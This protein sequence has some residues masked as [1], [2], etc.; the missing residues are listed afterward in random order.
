MGSFNDHRKSLSVIAFI[1][2]TRM[3]LMSYSYRKKLLVESVCHNLKPDYD[4]CSD[5]MLMT[6]TL[7]KH[8]IIELFHVLN[9]WFYWWVGVVPLLDILNIIPCIYHV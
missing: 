6:Y 5:V 7:G 1:G 8:C 9:G 4:I 3:I 2:L